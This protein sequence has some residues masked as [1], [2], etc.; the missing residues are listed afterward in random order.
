[1]CE[2]LYGDRFVD[3]RLGMWLN[4]AERKSFMIV[5]VNVNAIK[6]N[7]FIDLQFFNG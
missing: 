1:M 6:G 3:D 2:K 4:S 5:D 7:C